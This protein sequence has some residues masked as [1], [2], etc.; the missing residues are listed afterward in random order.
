M[1]KEGLLYPW[2][3]REEKRKG[4]GPTYYFGYQECIL[5][6]AL[7]QNDLIISKTDGK[8]SGHKSVFTEVGQGCPS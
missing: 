8:A 3:V 1:E 4:Q 6:I 7:S 5:Q 2:C